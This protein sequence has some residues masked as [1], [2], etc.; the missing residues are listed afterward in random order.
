MPRILAGLGWEVIQFDPG[1]PRRQEA[2]RLPEELADGVTALAAD[3]EDLWLAGP[4][5]WRRSTP[6]RALP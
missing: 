6:L 1:R 3:G 2:G 5:G 4:A